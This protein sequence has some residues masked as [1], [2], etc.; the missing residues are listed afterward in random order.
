M[1]GTVCKFALVALLS[2]AACVTA[3]HANL[4]SDGS[5]ETPVV[6]VGSFQNFNGG[7][8]LGAWTSGSGGQV[9]IVSG[10]FVQGGIN[11][12]AEDGTQWLDLT[13]DGANSPNDAV[14]Q[15][16]PTTIGTMYTLS[17]FVGNVVNPEGIFGRTS[18]VFVSINGVVSKGSTNS[19]GAGTNTQNWE[20]FGL[21]FT[22][23]S[24]ST[25][26]AFFNGDPTND[27]SNGLDN[28]VLVAAST[29][30]P[31]PATLALLS[32]ALAGMGL[33]RR[34]KLT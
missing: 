17:Y 25:T 30:V 21:T 14:Q 24:A 6:T 5:F 1:S 20:E 11:F 3:A 18:T 34:R 33:A 7:A 32:L 9:S 23:G 29:P 10:S 4:V 12:V 27:N 28:V 22:A 19:G 26:I 2:M 13:G 31:E 8:A 15:T 16:V